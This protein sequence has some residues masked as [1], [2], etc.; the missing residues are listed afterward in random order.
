[1]RVEHFDVDR[2]V[3]IYVCGEKAPEELYWQEELTVKWF[4]GLL[5]WCKKPA[6]YYNWYTFSNIPYSEDE[7]RAEGYKVYSQDER[8]VDRVVNK[9]Y[10][11][12]YLE[13]ENRIRAEFE[14]EEE[15]LQWVDTLKATSKKTFEIVVYEN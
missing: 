11:K 7:L 15:M 9:C 2:I 6:G 5:V 4:F 13:H 8:L 10:A 3:S 14:T 12:V 1:M